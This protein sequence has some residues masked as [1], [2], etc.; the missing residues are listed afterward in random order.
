STATA[1]P[2]PN[3][4]QTASAFVG[5]VAFSAKGDWTRWHDY[6]GLAVQ[7]FTSA[8]VKSVTFDT[9]ALPLV[10]SLNPNR[11]HVGTA[12]GISASSITFTVSPDQKLFTL[13]FA[14]GSFGAGD[15]FRF[16]MS[17]FTPI[18]GSTQEDPDRFRGMKITVSMSDGT[19]ATG[20]VTA[21]APQ[22]VNRFT[23]FGLVNAFKAVQA[24]RR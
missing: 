23:G 13:N 24:V 17:V 12:N 2:L 19:T 3:D 10:F 4:R 8:T 21:N 18:E 14:P 5:P 7:P 9:R 1:V 15:A 11:F 16:G 6:F 22:A 20:T